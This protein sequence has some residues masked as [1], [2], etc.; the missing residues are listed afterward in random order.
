MTEIKV[1]TVQNGIVVLLDY[2]LTVDGEEMD[3][4]PIQYL[5]GHNNII[6]GLEAALVGMIIGESR[7]VQV[8]AVDAY[9]EY[10]ES[11]VVKITRA[12]FP[13]DFE[14]KLGHPLRIRDESGHIFNGTVTALDED[15]IEFDMNH[16]LA[17]KDLFFK[18]TIVDLRPA[19]PLEIEQGHV[20][21]QCGSCGSQGC[22]DGCGG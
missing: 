9:G 5:H 20:Q 15:D 17:G 7:D 21:S 19:T 12:S 18:T 13:P 3:A 11:N 14:I 1:E 16:P 2:T 4:G 6:S 22:G 8:S 10:D